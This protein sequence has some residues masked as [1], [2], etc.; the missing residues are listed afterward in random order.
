LADG[1]SF[2]IFE[3]VEVKCP[4]IFTTA[5]DQYAIQAFK[6]NSV[7]Y[8]LKPFSTE[9][10]RNAIEK[11]EQLFGNENLDVQSILE[12]YHKKEHQ[13]QKRFI[14]YIGDK[15]RTVDSEEVAY[16][17]A[18]GK[19]VFLFTTTGK[20]YVVDFTLDRL[21]E[22]L[23]PEKFY[24]INRQFIVSMN[25]VSMMHIYPKGRVKIDL[26]PPSSKDAIVSIERS[27]GFKKWLNS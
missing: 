25:G 9:D 4:V 21:T 17:F 24:R 12:A 3:Q 22:I 13:W 10:L 18:E 14:V 16:F 26:N 15:I 7:D 5:Y 23:D 1:L 20:E 19:Y 27:S 6:V 8:L 11:Y 2:G